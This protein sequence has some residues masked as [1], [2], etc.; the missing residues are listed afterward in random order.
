MCRRSIDG[1][2]RPSIAKRRNISPQLSGV[3]M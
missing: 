1:W 2:E 3:E